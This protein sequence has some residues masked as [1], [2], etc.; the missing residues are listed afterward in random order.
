[1]LKYKTMVSDYEGLQGCLD[2][3][4]S[5]GWRL[6]SLSPDTWR[7]SMPS[8]EKDGDVPFNTLTSGGKASEEY[9]AS[10]YL[11]VFQREEYGDVLEMVGIA[12]EDLPRSELSPYE[13]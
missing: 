4:A 7:K 9:S 12:E 6:F 13:E 11:L 5:Q 8:A 2:M 10:Y 3:H 1:M